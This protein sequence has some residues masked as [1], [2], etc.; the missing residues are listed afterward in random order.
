M[1]S[2]GLPCQQV[3]LD[4]CPLH[5]LCSGFGSLQLFFVVYLLL[6][7]HVFIFH[8][9]QFQFLSV[10]V[11]CHQYLSFQSYLCSKS[12]HFFSLTFP[13]FLSSAL[14]SLSPHLLTPSQSFTLALAEHAQFLTL[15]SKLTRGLSA[16]QFSNPLDLRPLV[17]V[18]KTAVHSAIYTPKCSKAPSCCS[19]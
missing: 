18:Q 16:T 9:L 13:L 7:R 6:S 2:L 5:P 12:S 11:S 15:C 8:R 14:F 10:S 4:L 1:L 17:R 19:K 3:F